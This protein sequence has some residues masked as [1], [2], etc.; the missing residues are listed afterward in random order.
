MNTRISRF[1]TTADPKTNN[2]FFKLNS[3]WWSRFYEYPWAA[4]FIEKD[5]VSLDAACGISHPFKFHLADHCA[6]TYALDIDSRILNKDAIKQD[7]I[8]DF[9]EVEAVKI[10]NDKYFQ[11]INYVKAPLNKIPYPNKKF[12]KIYC[13]SVLEHINDWSGKLLPLNKFTWLKKLK[14]DKFYK[15]MREFRRVLKDDGFIILT[16]DYPTVNLSYLKRNMARLSLEFISE[17]SFNLTSDAII[18]PEKITSNGSR[19][20]CFRAVLRKKR[21]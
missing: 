6:E 19:L 10:N 13:L 12:D 20:Y 7:V 11:S 16:F 15:T 4:K 1:F 14:T 17:T 5:D 9:G 21:I 2:F 18:S 3:N 8:K